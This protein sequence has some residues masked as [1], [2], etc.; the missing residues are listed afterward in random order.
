[1]YPIH[2]ELGIDVNPTP[3]PYAAGQGQQVLAGIPRQHAQS[4]PPH[5]RVVYAQ[6]SA[7]LTAEMRR[8]EG[9][10]R[11]NM[12]TCNLMFGFG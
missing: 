10:M 3:Q 7:A 5:E 2:E 1:M 4:E 6:M 11:D 8:I 9:R 12:V